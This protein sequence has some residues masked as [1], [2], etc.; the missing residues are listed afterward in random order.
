MN[1]LG[2]T[3]RGE[4]RDTSAADRVVSEIKAAGGEAVANYDSVVEGA[5]VVQ[6][7][8]DTWGRVDIVINKSERNKHTHE[9]LTRRQR[10]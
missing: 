6:T 10:R 5:K 3:T 7:A 8:I 9:R 2:G 4:G 1:D